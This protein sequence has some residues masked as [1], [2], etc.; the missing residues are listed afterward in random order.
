[1]NE[2]DS[3]RRKK[4]NVGPLFY[5][6]KHSLFNYCSSIYENYELAHLGSILYSRTETLC[7]YIKKKIMEIE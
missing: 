7:F 4:H 6:L 3:R 2:L 5:G 1:M